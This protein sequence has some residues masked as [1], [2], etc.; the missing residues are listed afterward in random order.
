MS[1]RLDDESRKAQNLVEGAVGDGSKA[2]TDLFAEVKS[3]PIRTGMDSKTTKQNGPQEATQRDP[4]GASTGPLVAPL[5]D[6]KLLFKAFIEATHFENGQ[7]TFKSS[8]ANAYRRQWNMDTELK[9][10]RRNAAKRLG[11]PDD[12]N[13]SNVSNRCKGSRRA[14]SA[15]IWSLWDVPEEQIPLP[16][17]IPEWDDA[18]AEQRRLHMINTRGFNHDIRSRA[19]EYAKLFN[20]DEDEVHNDGGDEDDFFADNDDLDQ[21][22][23]YAHWTGESKYTSP[24]GIITYR[25]LARALSEIK[26]GKQDSNY[27]L[28][29]KVALSFLPD[30]QTVQI[31]VHFDHGS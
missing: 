19:S 7:L 30:E 24:K 10:H 11:A 18:F 27:E 15:P 29:T 31:K 22:E 17:V 1:Q 6:L 5:L 14:R 4:R 20:L 8:L 26:S 9:T 21:P 3:D 2:S 13:R 16:P 28:F 25:D 12:E 23:W